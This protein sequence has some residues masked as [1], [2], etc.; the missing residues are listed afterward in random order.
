MWHE[1]ATGNRFKSGGR[2]AEL[3]LELQL[4]ANLA[5]RAAQNWSS[6]L[7]RRHCPVM[8]KTRR[9]L[10]I[11]PP[12]KITGSILLRRFRLL[13]GFRAC[14]VDL[15]C[16]AVFFGNLLVLRAKL[17][18]SL[19]FF[20]RLRWASFHPLNL[21]FN[22]GLGRF[23]ICNLRHNYR[24]GLRGCWSRFVLLAVRLSL[25]G[26][27]RWRCRHNWLFNSLRLAGSHGFR[28][29]AFRLAANNRRRLDWTCRCRLA[30]RLPPRGRHR[31][32]CRHSW[33][34][35]SLKLAGSHRFRFA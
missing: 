31:W 2:S 35:N 20:L 9:S 22:F 18:Y 30:V 16:S 34:L 17:F 32:R 12:C 25:R 11:S 8:L 6:A 4:C 3:Q 27:C 26:G 15:I 1:L 14:F 7:R 21:A 13:L 5:A 10:L 29:A 23:F 28:F 19:A 24:S 33:L